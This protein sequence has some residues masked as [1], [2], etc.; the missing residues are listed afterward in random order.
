MLPVGEDRNSQNFAGYL[1][2]VVTHLPAQELNDRTLRI[3]GQRF[4]FLQIAEHYGESVKIVRAPQFPDDIDDRRLREYL[5]TKG[6]AGAGTVTYNIKTN[7]DDFKLD[8]DLWPDHH[9][10]TVS[11]TLGL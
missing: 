9:W 7:K 3:E 8:N 2:Y 5:Q 11:Q 6:E 1:A 10:L 4:S